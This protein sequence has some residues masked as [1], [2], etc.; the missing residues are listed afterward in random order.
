M[1]TKITTLE[2][3]QQMFVETL[4]NKT[5]NVTKISDTSVLGGI[6]YGIAKI[7]QKVTKD[8]AVIE[9]RLFPD[10]AFGTYLDDIAA[11]KGVSP[12]Q[13]ALQSSA[14]VR[15]LATPGTQYNAGVHT[16]TGN[17]GITFD[18]QQSV[19]IP[20]FG[21]TYAKVRSQSTSLA[22]NVD[23]LTITKVTPIPT[24]HTNV[25]NEYPATGGQDD[26]NDAIFR[27]RI[28][29]EI[30]VLARHSLSFLEH[31]FN[32]INPNV[33]R[34]FQYGF[35]ADNKILIGV[36]TVNGADLTL[37]EFNDLLVKCEQYFSLCESRPYGVNN[38]GIE[39]RNV[40]W[41]P[42]DISFRCDVDSS[43]DVDT[44]RKQIQVSINKEFD[45][46]YWTWDKKIE[47]DNLLEIVKNTPGVKYVADNQF[48]PAVDIRVPKYQLPRVRGFQMLDLNGNIIANYTGTLN[49]V[50]YPTNVDFWYQSDLLAT[51]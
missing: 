12:R 39:L 14:Y 2:E 46:R 26:E 51:I 6:S 36:L 44:V 28:K 11:L 50:Y 27:E 24:G 7:G 4:L 8:V 5:D 16:F 38:I 40:S 18:L 43:Y 23:A 30:N 33:L 41:L 9:S 35:T 34:C 45:Y 37:S 29:R 22:S 49:P 17:H 15:I 10:T 21:F 19:T 48:F 32:K 31:V 3:L 25:I 42:V 20:S 47:W 1:I 13:G